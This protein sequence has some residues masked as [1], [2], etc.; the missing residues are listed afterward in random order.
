MGPD[1]L[2]KYLF[3][4]REPYQ[5]SIGSGRNRWLATPIF[6]WCSVHW[7]PAWALLVCIFNI[8]IYIK[9]FKD[10]FKILRV[11]LWD[12]DVTY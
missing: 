5:F 4:P 6:Y 3:G 12:Y 10:L 9:D 1:S 7:Y 2:I 8:Y 11:I